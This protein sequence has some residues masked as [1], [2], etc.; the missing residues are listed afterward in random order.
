[1]NIHSAGQECPTL[2]GIPRGI[3][4]AGFRYNDKREKEKEKEREKEKAWKKKGGRGEDD[5]IL[6][7]PISGSLKIKKFKMDDIPPVPPIPSIPATP[8]IVPS[9]P[10]GGSFFDVPRDGAGN[11]SKANLPQPHPFAGISSTSLALSAPHPGG[12]SSLLENWFSRGVGCPEAGGLSVIEP[13]RPL[14]PP[15]GTTSGTSLVLSDPFEG[16]GA[17]SHTGKSH[18]NGNVNGNGFANGSM[19][20][21][22]LSV[23]EKPSTPVPP[24]SSS[25]SPS[26]SPSGQKE[27]GHHR[28]KSMS[29]PGFY[30]AITPLSPSHWHLHEAVVG[31][32]RLGPY[33]LA[34][35]ERMMGIYL[36]VYVHRDVRHLVRGA[37]LVFLFMRHG[38]VL[39]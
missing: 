12:W 20:P 32:Q 4:A 35:K 26:P 34:H 8:G 31:S 9:T 16:D 36:A 3:G 30:R 5:D 24:S 11:G 1:M 37:L 7:T 21:Y 22:S 2:S 18:I 19:S 28:K 10:I 6:E 13:D 27:P 39:T 14:P 25:P 15:V 38:L 17:S 29:K 33:E 23:P